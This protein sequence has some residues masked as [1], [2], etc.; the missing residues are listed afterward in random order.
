[1]IR[2]PVC[3][4]NR[5]PVSANTFSGLHHLWNA[6][7]TSLWYIEACRI[8]VHRH[9]LRQNLEVHR[10]KAAVQCFPVRYIA[11]RERLAALNSD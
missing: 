11:L 2:M 3:N 8:I 7:I 6:L 10:G 9:E 1:M 4:M 5:N